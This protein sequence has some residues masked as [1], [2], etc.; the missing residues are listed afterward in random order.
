MSNKDYEYHGMIASSW[1]LLRGDTA[2]IPDRKFFRDVIKHSG[3]PVPS[4]VVGPDVYY[5][6]TSQ[7]VST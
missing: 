5:L 7:M 3:E 1:D 6:N 2:N 4:S